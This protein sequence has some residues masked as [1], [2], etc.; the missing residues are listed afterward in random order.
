MNKAII[1]IVT[2]LL[3][4]GVC[5]VPSLYALVWDSGYHEFNAGYESEV[6]MFN[7]ATADITGGEIGILAGW[8]TSSVFVYEPSEIGLLRPFDSSTANVFD[9]TINKLF[10][11][12]S[13]ITRIYDGSL[14]VIQA[15]DTS[16][17]FL[18]V[19]SYMWDPSGGTHDGG[20]LT[21]FWL[22]TMNPF[23]IELQI[24]GVIEHLNFVPE[25]STMVLFVLGCSVLA[26]NRRKSGR[27][28]S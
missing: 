28:T 21:G 18:Y 6:D 1:T 7:D 3:V 5:N 11:G 26:V 16:E 8:D 2:V 12:G 20:L 14:N 25:P 24:E 17:I 15:V 19:E 22:D 10:A 27:A 9:G 13:S 23:T 4:M